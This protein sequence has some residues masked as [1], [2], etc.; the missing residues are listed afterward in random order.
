MKKL[1]IGGILLISLNAVAQNSLLFEVTGNGMASPSYLFGTMHVQDEAAF[2]WNDSVFWAINQADVAAFE[3]DF[4]AKKLKKDLKPSPAQMKSWENFI[5]KDLSPAIEKAIPADTLGKRLADFYTTLL[6]VVLEKDKKQRGTFVDLFLQEYAQKNNKEVVGIES[7]KEQLNIFLDIDKQMLKKT[8]LDF[9]EADNWDIDPNLITGSHASLVEAYASKNITNV[10]EVMNKETTKSSNE[11]INQLY[12]R[13]F[14]DRNEIMAKRTLKMLKN[15]SHFIAVGAGH[16]CG[17]SGLM[18]QLT[19]AGY[20]LRAMD[21]TSNSTTTLNW[22]MY[23]SEVYS[24]K[25]PQGVSAIDPTHSDYEEYYMNTLSGNKNASIYTTKGKATFSIEYVVS[26]YY[27]DSYEVMEY[28]DDAYEYE[29]EMDAPADEAYDYEE[30][31]MIESEDAYESLGIDEPKEIEADYEIEY[32]GEEVEEAVEEEPEMEVLDESYD[33]QEDYYSSEFGDDSNKNKK[34]GK[35]KKSNK[36]FETDYWKTVSKTVMSQAMGQM[37]AAAMN[38][39][40]ADKEDEV[41]EAQFVKIMGKDVE[42][43]SSNNYLGYTKKVAIEFE[44]G[45]YE[46]SVTGD[47]ALLDSGELDAFFT[48]FVIK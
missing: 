34:E 45:F 36:P 21:I 40:G 26:S 22:S 27:N 7:V 1:L 29:E 10:C 47:P 3:I 44:D 25:V 5:V 17:E 23:D 31:P 13:I 48:S 18:E 2:G 12:R 14:E 30:E 38:D 19:K 37:M 8:I 46:L 20:T 33:T 9:I 39:V 43:E 16:L 24:V 28:A 4:D 11:L 41:T 32:V 6:T 42:V 15:K 35:D